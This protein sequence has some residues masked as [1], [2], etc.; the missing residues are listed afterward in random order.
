MKRE[1]KIVTFLRHYNDIDHIVPV[2]YKWA[3]LKKDPVDIIITSSR[4]YLNDY[5]IQLLKE[6]EGIRVHFIEDFLSGKQRKEIESL[7]KFSRMS[8]FSPLRLIKRS[9]PGGS[10]PFRTIYLDDDFIERL[11]E[12]IFHHSVGGIVIFDWLLSS[13]RHFE[14]V[15]KIIEKAHNLGFCAIS[16][17]HGDSPHYNRMIRLNELNYQFMDHY[18]AG[19]VFDF[20]VVPNELCARRYRPHMDA[21]RIKVLGSPRYN[22]EWI[23]LM[24]NLIPPYE[25]EKSNDKLKIVFFLRNFIYPIFWEEVIR[26]IKLVT[27]FQDFYLIVKHHTRDAKLDRLL[28]THPELRSGE[29]ENLE[30][31]YNDVHSSALLQWADVVMDL[32]TSVAF[33]AVKRGKPVLSMEYLHSSFSTVPYYIKSCDIRCR[34]DLYNALTKFL[35]NP[36]HPFYEKDQRKKF[37]EEIIDFPDSNVLNRYVSF[38][39]S[40]FDRSTCP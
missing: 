30:F 15:K 4:D 17:P 20:V 14:F 35:S 16:L 2:I 34:D 19:A 12:Q 38:I 11:F 5:R 28:Q 25:T 29:K 33:E 32:G 36:N 10:N 6:N 24:E 37:L 39:Q 9:K 1:Y 27:Q 40:C 18:A 31:V 7:T 21:K 26:T 22:S 8:K 3:Q 13:A 23:N